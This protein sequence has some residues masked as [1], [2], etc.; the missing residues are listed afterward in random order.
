MGIQVND[1]ITQQ[2]TV[3]NRCFGDMHIFMKPT[4][5]EY[6]QCGQKQYENLA[7]DD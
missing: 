3:N 1:F 7:S 5:G 2:G 4:V 6:C